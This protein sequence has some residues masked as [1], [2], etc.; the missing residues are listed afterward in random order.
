MS[1]TVFKGN[2]IF[3][4]TQQFFQAIKAKIALSV[5]G[6]VNSIIVLD[7]CIDCSKNIVFVLYNI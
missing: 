7:A 3:V 1:I 2:P 4:A 6:N 5:D